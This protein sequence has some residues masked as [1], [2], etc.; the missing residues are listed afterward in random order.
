MPER[1]FSNYQIKK[2]MSTEENS[3]MEIFNILHSFALC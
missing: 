2:K 1:N 3:D